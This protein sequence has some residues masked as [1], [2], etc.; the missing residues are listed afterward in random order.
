MGTVA[1][2]ETFHSNQP[3]TSTQTTVPVTTRTSSQPLT[4]ATSQTEVAS[5][6]S[7]TSAS[8]TSSSSSS[9]TSEVLGPLLFVAKESV[10]SIDSEG[11]HFTCAFPGNCFSVTPSYSCNAL[12]PCYS[13]STLSFP[14][15]PNPPIV[16]GQDLAI[17]LTYSPLGRII[18]DTVG[19]AIAVS[20]DEDTL[21]VINESVPQTIPLGWGA[22]LGDTVTLDVYS[23][24]QTRLVAFVGV[25]LTGPAALSVNSLYTPCLSACIFLAGQSV[26]T[27]IFLQNSG[28]TPITVTSMAVTDAGMSISTIQPPLPVSVSFFDVLFNVTLTL[29]QNDYV[30]YLSLTAVGQSS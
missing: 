5:A 24:T 22:K 3:T 21:L 19:K 15:G 20:T 23:E 14:N 1:V 10:T 13:T 16:Y 17:L 4:S 28:F 29:S 8:T 26:E 18:Y 7:T 25:N 11:A 2:V 6:M 27:E 9:A 30:G 12:V